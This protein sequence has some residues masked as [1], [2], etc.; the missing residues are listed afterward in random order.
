MLQLIARREEI[1]RL[2]KQEG[3]LFDPQLIQ[4]L[5]SNQADY[6]GKEITLHDCTDPLGAKRH[7]S[8]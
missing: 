2:K 4:N 5:Q 8:D 3:G 7:F 1:K 6:M